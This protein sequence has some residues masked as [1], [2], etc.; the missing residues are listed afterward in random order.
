MQK[1]APLISPENFEKLRKYLDTNPK[2]I[3]LTHANPD[4]DAIGSALSL[5]LGL[6]NGGFQSSVACLDP[7]PKTFRFL[8]HTNEFLT[9][10]DENAF[11][12]VIF[13]DCG[14]KKMTRFHDA[15]PRILSDKMV[16]I[17]IDHHPSNDNFGDINF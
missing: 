12:A 8:A 14:D 4:G 3:I 10:F 11:D 5:H 7:V 1:N 15:K 9:D 16:K 2:L 6:K 13:L 17:N